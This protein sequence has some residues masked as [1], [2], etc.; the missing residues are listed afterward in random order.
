MHDSGTGWSPPGFPPVRPSSRRREPAWCG[1]PSVSV[2]I[3]A[4]T[5]FVVLVSLRV[6]PVFAIVQAKTAHPRFG[7]WRIVLPA[8][9]SVSRHIDLFW[10][11]TRYGG[12]LV[13]RLGGGSVPRKDPLV[14]P[15][16][17]SCTLGDSRYVLSEASRV[18]RPAHHVHRD[19]SGS[20]RGRCK[21][22]KLPNNLCFIFGHRSAQNE[23]DLRMCAVWR[24]V[25]VIQLERPK[26]CCHASAQPL[27]RVW[28][29]K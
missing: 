23:G 15:F 27:V 6:L 9:R 29:R 4:Q 19:L 26:L 1:A 7:H 11:L 13:P 2:S 17:R 16:E 28:R 10:F 22:E 24:H 8:T 14:L 12:G 20:L 25:K 21:R 5:H 18:G 3:A